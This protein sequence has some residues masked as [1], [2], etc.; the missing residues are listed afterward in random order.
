MTGWLA[1]I[2]LALV[3]GLLYLP[4]GVLVVYSFNDAHTGYR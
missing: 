1:R 2:Y 4:I 3:Y